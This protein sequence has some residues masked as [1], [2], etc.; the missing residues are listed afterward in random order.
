MGEASAS[1]T[2]YS[3]A[4]FLALAGLLAL[5]RF[6]RLAKWAAGF[7]AASAVKWRED[8]L[9]ASVSELLGRAGKEP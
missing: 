1:W 7:A 3:T 6:P 2:R 9:G 4:A 8:H 5:L